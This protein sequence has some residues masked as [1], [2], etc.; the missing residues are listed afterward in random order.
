M[1]KIE[2]QNNTGTNKSMWF[3]KWF[4]DK[5][6]LD[7]YQ[8]RDEED[9]RW[10]INLL[11]RSI[12]VKTN[13]SVL[14]IACGSGRHSI[15][16]ARRGFE[17]TGFDLS[18]FLINEARK[19]LKNSGEKNMKVKFLIRDM[20]DFN[21]RN[22]FDI[23]V[24][25]FTSFGYFDNDKENFSVIENVSRSL[26]KGGYFVFDFLNKHFLEKN[27]KPLSRNKIGNATVIQKRKLENG[28]VRK[29]III[30]RNNSTKQF[31]EVL[32]LYSL[33]DFNKAFTLSGLK[34]EKIFGD[35]FGNKYSRTQSGRLIIIARKIK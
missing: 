1:I 10:I 4:S 19:N 9:A 23:A 35:Y 2:N 27:L 8:H 30:T 16:L 3:E 11:Q 21:F 12:A 31:E 28:F 17:V 22:T 13:A 32:K 29:K 6:Y 5:L 25:I 26:K 14:D 7:L 18:E 24:N 15:E 34:T 33:Q 20:R